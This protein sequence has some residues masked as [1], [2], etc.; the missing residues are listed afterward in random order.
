MIEDEQERH[1]TIAMDLL[2]KFTREE[3]K[4]AK[5]AAKPFVWRQFSTGDEFRFLLELFVD[6]LSYPGLLGTHA[7]EGL[8][9]V[10]KS[11]PPDGIDSDDLVKILKLVGDEK[12]F[13]ILLYDNFKQSAIG[14][15]KELAVATFDNQDGSSISR[16]PSPLRDTGTWQHTFFSQAD[17]HKNLLHDACPIIR[18]VIRD[19]IKFR[20]CAIAAC[21][22]TVS[23]S[24]AFI[25]P[26]SPSSNTIKD[27]EENSRP[28]P[29]SAIRPAPDN[30]KIKLH[31]RRGEPQVRCRASKDLPKP[32]TWVHSLKD[33]TYSV[34][35]ARIRASVA[36]VAG[37]EWPNGGHPYIRPTHTATQLNYLELNEDNC[38]QQITKAWRA[39]SKRL[40]HSGEEYINLF[41]YLS[42]PEQ[43]ATVG[44]RNPSQRA[45]L[46][47][48]VRIHG[49]KR[50]V[51]DASQ[52]KEFRPIKLMVNGT[53]VTYSIEI[54]SLRKALGYPSSA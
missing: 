28:I 26:S 12:I 45:I 37:V 24:P 31:L 32:I 53:V 18:I 46:D 19:G 4:D 21:N 33:D 22:L 40:E 51:E 52:L 9:Q 48:Q 39:E 20:L 42:R 25:P 1:K 6:D 49:N 36:G 38:S 5:A 10:I 30:V 41:I 3:L 44:S 23:T 11:A 43:R 50:Q 16:L 17:D 35:C 27:S 47:E 29:A 34:L 15:M 2:C 8:D 14:F 13:G 7:L 54:R